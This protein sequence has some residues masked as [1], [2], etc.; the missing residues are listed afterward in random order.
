[1][2]IEWNWIQG[3]AGDV[4]SYTAKMDRRVL[5]AMFD[6]GVI[7][8]CKALQGSPARTVLVQT[9]QATVQGDDASNLGQQYLATITAVETVAIGAAPASGT[10]IDLVGLQVQDIDGGGAAGNDIVTKVIAGTVGAG[11]PATPAS[12]LSI[13]SVTISAGQTAVTTAMITDL[14]V[15][16]GPVMPVG[17]M[18]LWYGSDL[19]IPAGWRAITAV[20]G[21]T[22]GAFGSF[23]DLADLLNVVSGNIV[24][25]N[26][27]GR[28]PVGIDPSDATIDTVGELAGAGTVTLATGNLPAHQH[29]LNNHVHT[30]FTDND[31]GTHVHPF[32]GSTS[33]DTHNHNPANASNDFV[34]FNGTGNAGLSL[35]AGGERHHT[36]TDDTHN[37]TMS[38]VTSP[39]T[40]PHSHPFTTGGPTPSISEPAGSGT[41]FSV[42]PP[43]VAL[44]L[45]LRVL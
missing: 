12:F 19:R 27:R 23:P 39:A 31:A 3:T 8:G 18:M 21:E 29:G 17:S 30:G 44:H 1:M 11:V 7:R 36:T 40:F 32:S 33:F 15:T 25:A 2:T 24:V 38:G 37:H 43:V 5:S 9:G 22:V 13:C 26:M 6:E 45:L 28:I 41:A 34:A 16:A 20:G 14:R 35:A 4:P 42:R 10:R